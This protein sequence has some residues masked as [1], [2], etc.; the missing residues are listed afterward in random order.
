MIVTGVLSHNLRQVPTQKA[1]AT[2]NQELPRQSASLFNN[3]NTMS[4]WNRL[5]TGIL[6]APIASSSAVWIGRFIFGSRGQE[7]AHRGY[8]T[9]MEGTSVVSLPPRHRHFQTSTLKKT[10]NS[11]D[12]TTAAV[13]FDVAVCLGLVLLSV[14]ALAARQQMRLFALRLLDQEQ[15]ITTSLSKSAQV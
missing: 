1:N 15:Q 2:K 14:G 3:Y 8:V 6:F 12:V 13:V 7:S 5:E 11:N 4:L 10:S 9:Y